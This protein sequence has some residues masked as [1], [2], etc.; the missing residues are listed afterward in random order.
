VTLTEGPEGRPATAP[1]VA[2]TTRLDAD[3]D[4]LA[5]AGP[6]GVL[7]DGP[8]SGLAGRGE[9]MRLPL[10][11]GPGRLERAAETIGAALAAIAVDDE[12]GAPGCGP[13]AFLAAPFADA[14][15]GEAVVPSLVVG[16]AVDGTR[17]VTT[18]G[19][20][21]SAR[22]V[23]EAQGEPDGPAPSSYSVRPR[24]PPE[25]WCEAVAAARDAVRAGHLDKVVLAREVVVEADA[26]L[27]PVD[28]L[29]RLRAAYPSSMR[30][31]V[32][33]FL[34]ASP[35]LL[36][37]RTGD[38]VRSHP[39][40]GTAPRSADP[41]TDARLAAALLASV[42]DR[43]E[44]QV[45]I[46]T[47]LDS[48][49]PF[50]SYVDAEAEPSVVAMANVAHLASQV[51]GRL[52]SPPAS[53]LT[54]AAA[55]HPTPAVCGA[56]RAEALAT[57]DALE[58]LDRGRYAGPVGWV[59]GRGNG[60]FAVAIRCAELDGPRARLFAGNGIV[61]DSDPGAELAETRAKLQ[62]LLSAMIQP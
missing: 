13:V 48:L 28:V 53:A 22:P 62:A 15:A 12:V 14:A 39:M 24:R 31:A 4:L 16:R 43:Q 36:V 40:A 57:I 51:E 52:S 11:T 38:V 5:V 49:L 30:F 19:P 9:A 42:K 41:S 23:L 7:F 46:D 26:P 50:C 10:P 33:G 37:A 3:P 17:F 60:A 58:S 29:S 6:R 25:E 21:G 18:V 27:R 8:A 59:D 45:T 54:L 56:P 2:R 44:H 55:L 1:L 32:D 61:G 47:V 20:V 34:G 35:E